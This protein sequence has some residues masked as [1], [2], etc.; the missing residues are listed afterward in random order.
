MFLLKIQGHYINL[1]SNYFL[2]YQKFKKEGT[3]LKSQRAMALAPSAPNS[4]P[5]LY[6][7][8]SIHVFITMSFVYVEAKPLEILKFMKAS[9][10]APKDL[11]R[12]HISS[13]LQ[14]IV[15][16]STDFF[17][18]ASRYLVKQSDSFQFGEGDSQLHLHDT[19]NLF[20]S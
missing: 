2:F 17:S 6:W 8:Y 14:V 16:S 12:D 3:C 18:T 13:H 19:E 11:T 15:I 10:G 4:I 1:Y 7:W 5:I 9:G 20:K